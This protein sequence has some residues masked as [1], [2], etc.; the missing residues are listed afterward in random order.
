[1]SA[2][3]QIIIQKDKEILSVKAK[4]Y[5]KVD[6]IKKV[7]ELEGR[8]KALTHE[9]EKYLQQKATDELNYESLQTENN[10]L[11]QSLE[12]YQQEILVLKSNHDQNLDDFDNKFDDLQQKVLL[13]TQDNSDLKNKI[14]MQRDKLLQADQEKNY[15]REKCRIA[16]R[17]GEEINQKIG[18]LEN[19]LRTII[20]EKTYQ[21][22]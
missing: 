5:D 4:E 8:I 6:I 9:N 7:A 15:W 2:Q 14:Q 12:Q 16:E 13:L 3:K 17:K 20:M 10:Q 18:D 21:N 19:E 1:M 11:I 22:T